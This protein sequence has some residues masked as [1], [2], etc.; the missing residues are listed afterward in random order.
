MMLHQIIFSFKCRPVYVCII[1]EKNKNQ[2]PLELHAVWIR[3]K[4]FELKTSIELIANFLCY[5][6]SGKREK[7]N[8]QELNDRKK[9]DNFV[10]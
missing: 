1:Y 9:K 3:K 4:T 6:E 5:R 10:S 2:I 8:A 7:Q